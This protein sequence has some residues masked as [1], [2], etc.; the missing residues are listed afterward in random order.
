MPKGLLVYENNGA[1][2]VTGLGTFVV[3]TRGGLFIGVTIGVAG[4]AGSL[5]TIYD[6]SVATGTPIAVLDG[7]RP[8]SYWFNYGYKAELTV[9]Q[10]GAP[11][12][13]T[14]LFQP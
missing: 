12:S 10:A 13:F 14:V 2:L 3:D 9:V 11:A 6:G 7:T 4:A 1:L 8:G 5:I